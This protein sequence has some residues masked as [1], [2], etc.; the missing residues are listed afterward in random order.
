[1]NGRDGGRG[2][3]PEAAA[4]LEAGVGPVRSAVRAR[5]RRWQAARV[6][7]ALVVAAGAV[8]AAWAWAGRGPSVEMPLA[9]TAPPV[10]VPTLIDVKGANGPA[11]VVS[12]ATD[13]DLS[14]A[15]KELGTP[16][17]VR[18]GH[19]IYRATDVVLEMPKRPSRGSGGS[20][21]KPE[22]S[23]V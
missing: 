18:V 23:A 10:D 8:L 16:G 1:M 7:A 4:R 6:V 15:L 13:D 17:L 5:G 9:V 22:A 3:S 21:S 20:D 12:E 14:A 19:K 2:L 11:A